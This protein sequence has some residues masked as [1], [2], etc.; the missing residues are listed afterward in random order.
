[1]KI[2]LKYLKPKHQGGMAVYKILG[3]NMLK[4]KFGKKLINYKN[5]KDNQLK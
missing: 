5:L 2:G 3:G 4:I 1:M